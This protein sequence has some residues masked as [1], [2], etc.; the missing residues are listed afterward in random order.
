MFTGKL[1]AARKRLEAVRES[2]LAQ[3]R[4]ADTIEAKNTAQSEFDAAVNQI[5]NID[6][7]IDAEEEVR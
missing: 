6:L 2:A 5:W 4:Q 3:C 1:Y 7:L